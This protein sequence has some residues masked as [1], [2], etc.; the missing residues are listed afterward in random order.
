VRRLISGTRH[1]SVCFRDAGH[2]NLKPENLKEPHPNS[3]LRL[4]MYKTLKAQS[5]NPAAG[6]PLLGSGGSG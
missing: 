6:I 3:F 1:L 2:W 5:G 4:V